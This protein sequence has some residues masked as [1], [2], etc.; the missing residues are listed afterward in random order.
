[1]QLLRTT[2]I[3]SALVWQDPAANRDHF[4]QLIA[5][6]KGQTDLILLPEMFATGFTMLPEVHAEPAAGPTLRWMQEQSALTG[7]LLCGSLAV[8]DGGRFFNRFYWVSPQGEIGWYDKRHLFRMGAEP[9]HY[10]A[11]Q[12]R[13][14][15]EYRGWR[16]LPLV[17]YDLRFPVWCRSRNDYDLILC[18]ANWPQ[19]RRHAWR[20]LLMARAI[21][22]QCYLA[23]VNRIGQDGN[24]L[25]HSG[26]SLLVD[27]KGDTLIDRPAGTPFVATATLD[28]AALQRFRERFPAWQDADPFQLG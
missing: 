8:A 7:A 2:L 4:S 27:F 16:I 10:S 15:F 9:E 25:D 18:V 17:C 5:P 6:L 22:N 12:T 14:L 24:G 19:P 28:P 11:G 20:T 21:E 3:Q 1:M 26:D 23:G 13:A